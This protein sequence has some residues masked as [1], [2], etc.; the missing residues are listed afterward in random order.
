MGSRQVEKVPNAFF[1][2]LKSEYSRNSSVETPEIVDNFVCKLFKNTCFPG[3]KENSLNFK[4]P[5][6]T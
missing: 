4:N 1:S 3:F 5:L 2:S 6:L